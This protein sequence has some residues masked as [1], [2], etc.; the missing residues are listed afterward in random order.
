[1]DK[2]LQ[3][4]IYMRLSKEDKESVCDGWE[5]EESGS[6]RM[7]R[8]L[9][10][11]FV[12]EHF[13]HYR[14]LE[15][16][17]DGYSGTNFNRPGV[18]AMLKLVK[19]LAVDCIV[20]KDFSRFSRD[21]IEL[22]SYID[23]IFPFMGVRFI[24]VND[25]Y[26]S[27][28]CSGGIG[29]LDVSF[30]SLLYDLYSKDLSIKVKASLAAKKEKGLY[31]SANCPFGYGKAAGDK[32]R[33][34]IAEDEAAVVR[35]I[36][37]MAMEGMTSVQIA[38]AFNLEGVKTPIEFKIA[39]GKTS[40]RPKGAAFSWSSSAICQI[41]RNEAYV[42]DVAQGKYDKDGVGGK[43]HKKPRSEWKIF[44]NHH[45]PIIEREVFD[46]IQKSRGRKRQKVGREWHPLTGKLV[47]ACCGKN[48]QIR[49]GLEPCFC[50]PS[51][52]VNPQDG[53]VKKANAK[54]LEQHVLY[55][56]QQRVQSLADIDRM[57]K[58]RKEKLTQRLKEEK[59]KKRSVQAELQAFKREKLEC[60]ER[61]KA[62]EGKWERDG[63]HSMNAREEAAERWLVEIEKLI[64]AVKKEQSKEPDLAELLSFFGFSEL[65]GELV[66]KF[67][68][69]IIIKDEQHMEIYWQEEGDSFSCNHLT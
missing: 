62:G 17:D 10:Q 3:I 21:Y 22:G 66:Q 49:R 65:T 47:C 34:V 32:H 27:S 60:Y 43:T 9:L 5:G 8:L 7:Q 57:Q 51:L 19:E 42:G 20:V 12:E 55:E 44:R 64:E 56:I 52:Y 26:D 67:V 36:F 41:L 58:E 11:S 68:K 37:G 31:V 45:A 6:I 23:Q 35:R 13:S 18:M 33:L 25:G 15:F 61:Y 4:A 50:C 29:E 40:R 24:S 54:L 53:C 16:Q 38:R 63:L 1:M 14:L 28:Q 39:K 30:K 2:Q 46:E 69:R 59:R 48:L